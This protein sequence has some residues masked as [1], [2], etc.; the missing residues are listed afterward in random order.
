M[1]A[2]VL[3]GI[4]GREEDRRNDG[5]ALILPMNL[6]EGPRPGRW[7]EGQCGQEGERLCER[8]SPPAPSQFPAAASTLQS[9][10]LHPPPKYLPE[11]PRPRRGAGLINH[12]LPSV[13][14]QELNS[15]VTAA[16]FPAAPRPA[17]SPRRAHGSWL[18]RGRCVPLSPGLAL[19][20]SAWKRPGACTELFSVSSLCPVSV[21]DR[22]PGRDQ[23]QPRPL[24]HQG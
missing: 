3:D 16:L 4:R 24:M 22:R 13:S 15:F 12:P 23:R 14:A 21:W 9:L 20:L 2:S 8:L 7:S 5:R 11:L 19:P 1:P 18:P 10:L 6:W 17:H